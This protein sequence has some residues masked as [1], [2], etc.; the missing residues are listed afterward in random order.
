MSEFTNKKIVLLD[1]E[2][3]I[4]LTP[5]P[6][7]F[8]F[9]LRT[10]V[11][12]IYVY[13]T[14]NTSIADLTE[15]FNDA[16][17]ETEKLR[18][19]MCCPSQEQVFITPTKEAEAL[20]KLVDPWLPEIDPRKTEIEAEARADK[21]TPELFRESGWE[22][23]IKPELTISLT[24]DLETNVDLTGL[25]F[26]NVPS[27]N[28]IVASIKQTIDE[29][30]CSERWAQNE[31]QYKINM[32]RLHGTTSGIFE[33]RNGDR[34]EIPSPG[35]GWEIGGSEKDFW[36]HVFVDEVFE[37]HFEDECENEYWVHH[38]TGLMMLAEYR[39]RIE[40][41]TVRLIEYTSWYWR[42][43]K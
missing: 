2:V 19:S 28:E 20:R 16:I 5:D 9:T 10:N 3:H 25:N 24:S 17:A 18:A 7:E 21:E 27:M 33:F 4:D 42:G 39:A 34:F 35:Q 26:S 22:S 40:E 15:K 43:E 6:N 14:V 38:E 32:A 31:E 23:I 11:G 36:P 30:S 1:P 29:E 13:A 12:D 37:D 41:E 8:K